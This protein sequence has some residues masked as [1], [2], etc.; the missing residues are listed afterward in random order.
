[1]DDGGSPD[2]SGARTGPDMASGER[3]FRKNENRFQEGAW[4]K[5]KPKNL[6]P[7]I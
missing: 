4:Q 7:K 6:S 5:S 1:M 2:P 3:R